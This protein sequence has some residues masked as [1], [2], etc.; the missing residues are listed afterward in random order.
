MSFKGGNRWS[1]EDLDEGSKLA[2]HLKMM[3]N[4]MKDNSNHYRHVSYQLY[5]MLRNLCFLSFIFTLMTWLTMTNKT[6]TILTSIFFTSISLTIFIYH[7]YGDYSEKWRLAV[8]ARFG[9]EN[10][11]NCVT[12]D[13]ERKD[14]VSEWSVYSASVKESESQILKSIHI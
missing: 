2:E 11:A 6:W 13:L 5:I 7:E 3:A 8:G 10:L 4:R 12:T 14:H 9:L 1:V